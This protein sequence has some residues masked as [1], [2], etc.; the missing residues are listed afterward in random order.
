MD[1][2]A[3]SPTLALCAS[4]GVDGLRLWACLE[5][6]GTWACVLAVAA[7]VRG[8][9]ASLLAFS[10]DGSALAAAR[11][12]VVEVW[13]PASGSL[14]SAAG[15]HDPARAPRAL[16][17]LRGDDGYGTFKSRDD[18]TISQ[19]ISGIVYNYARD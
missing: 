11:P 16:G 15:A 5:K 4:S 7:V 18:D 17:F 8:A 14:L 9:S 10:G 6:E 13:D 12:G 3:F 19:T 2:L 1:A